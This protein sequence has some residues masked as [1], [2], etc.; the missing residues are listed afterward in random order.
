MISNFGIYKSCVLVECQITNLQRFRGKRRVFFGYCE[1][2]SYVINGVICRWCSKDNSLCVGVFIRLYKVYL[3]ANKCLST[4]CRLTGWLVF[5]GLC[6]WTTTMAVTNDSHYTSPT[7]CPEKGYQHLL[8]N[9]CFHLFFP[10]F[11]IVNI[12]NGFL[13]RLCPWGISCSIVLIMHRFPQH[14]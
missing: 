11:F 1:P 10:L 4:V 7:T 3:S 13:V 6:G 14:T 8:N 9:I 5:E 2:L 12:L